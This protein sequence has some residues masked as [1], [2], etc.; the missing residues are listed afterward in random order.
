MH[1]VAELTL[2]PLSVLPLKTLDDLHARDL[3]FGYHLILWVFA[4]LLIGQVDLSLGFLA[5]QIIMLVT[6]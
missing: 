6:Q 2:A 4:Q 5:F 3:I 1:V